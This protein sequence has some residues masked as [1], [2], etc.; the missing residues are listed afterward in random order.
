MYGPLYLAV[1][2]LPASLYFKNG[3][4]NK[5]QV[6]GAIMATATTPQRLEHLSPIK[7]DGFFIDNKR[8]KG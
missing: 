3:E 4:L 5:S 7:K 2:K 6:G 1:F 8:Y